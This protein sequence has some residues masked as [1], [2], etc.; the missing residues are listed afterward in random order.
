MTN[1]VRS[2]FPISYRKLIIPLEVDKELD[3][4]QGT[5]NVADGSM[6]GKQ[7]ELVHTHQGDA[8]LASIEMVSAGMKE[9]I[10]K[11][12]SKENKNKN[13]KMTEIG[14]AHSMQHTNNMIGSQETSTTCGNQPKS[15]ATNQILDIMGNKLPDSS[16]FTPVK[17]GIPMIGKTSSSTEI[18]VKIPSSQH[19][20][21]LL[22]VNGKDED[23]EDE[24]ILDVQEGDGNIKDSKDNKS[25]ATPTS[26]D[27]LHPPRSSV[28][29]SAPIT[30]T[31]KPTKCKKKSPAH[32]ALK[33]HS[34]C[35]CANGLHYIKD[36]LQ[37]YKGDKI[38]IEDL[39]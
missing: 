24:E 30:P 1:Q 28:L 29:A 12:V 2:Q 26:I 4:L 32:K 5:A 18:Y 6:I 8:S 10:C 20:F 3:Q 11:P 15:K 14:Q 21:D 16:E 22:G 38:S 37:Q 7:V 9:Q 19:R 17:K 31:T 35:H 25:M 34:Y 13:Q 27:L 33:D 23:D 39:T 36:Q